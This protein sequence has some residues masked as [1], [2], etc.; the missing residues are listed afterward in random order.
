[1]RIA[2]ASIISDTRPS[3]CDWTLRTP[4]PLTKRRFGHRGCAAQRAHMPSQ[5]PSVSPLVDIA[6]Q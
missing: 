3:T 1:M 4:G 5:P 2:I 6:A